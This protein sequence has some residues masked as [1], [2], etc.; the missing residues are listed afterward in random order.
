MNL[1]LDTGPVV[2]LLDKSEKHHS[3]CL[4][5]FK[6]F[7]GRIFSTEPVLTECLYLL[8]EN[9]ENQDKCLSFFIQAVELI[10]NNP[11]SL[12]RC[13]ELMKKYQDTPMDFADATLVSLA[14][15]L[16]CREI[17]TLDRRGFETFRWDRNKSFVIYPE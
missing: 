12:K 17:F 8:G 14:I 6:K 13:S 1:L 11:Q 5:F 2:A 4:E 15:D 10:P 7:K 9:F 3:Q 16:E